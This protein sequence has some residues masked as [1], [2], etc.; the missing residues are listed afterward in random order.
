M[1][2]GQVYLDR[3]ELLEPSPAFLRRDLTTISPFALG[4]AKAFAA[5]GALLPLLEACA[6]C[7]AR[8]A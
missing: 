7:G 8:V 6:T 4:S 3:D 1:M 2:S 5:V